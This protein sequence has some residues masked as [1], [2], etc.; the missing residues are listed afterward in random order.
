MRGGDGSTVT[1]EDNI[2]VVFSSSVIVFDILSRI[3][4]MSGA[5]FC[6]VDFNVTIVILNCSGV[7][8]GE[9]KILNLLLFTPLR[10]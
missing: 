7:W 8:K 5:L 6:C 1:G 9:R 10:N 3:C 2:D 4:W